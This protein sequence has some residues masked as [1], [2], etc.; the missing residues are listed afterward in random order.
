MLKKLKQSNQGFTIIEVLIVLAI[1]AL[2]ILIVF[3]AVPALQRQQRNTGRKSE[4][5]RVASSVV[6]FVGNNNGTQPTVT[7]DATAIYGN[8]GGPFKYLGALT[9]APAAAATCAAASMV[10]AKITICGV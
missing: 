3:L 6:D 7:A 5:A 10:N 2:I 4:G 1:A 9:G 8:A